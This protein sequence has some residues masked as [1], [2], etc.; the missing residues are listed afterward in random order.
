MDAE[1][2]PTAA[3]SLHRIYETRGFC[4]KLANDLEQLLNVMQ[5]TSRSPGGLYRAMNYEGVDAMFKSGFPTFLRKLLAADGLY[6]VQEEKA[7]WPNAFL[8][9]MGIP[10][11]DPWATVWKHRTRIRSYGSPIALSALHLCLVALTT[12]VFHM[13]VL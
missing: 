9:S 7:R 12:R 8:G 2:V 1:T 10:D 6:K 4:N 11:P 5:A 3:L 13:D